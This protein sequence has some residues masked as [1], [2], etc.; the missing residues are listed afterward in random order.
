MS[1][2]WGR[3]LTL[4]IFGESHGAAIGM[5]LAG[6]PPGLRIDWEAVRREMARRAPGRSPLA[7][8]RKEADDFEVLSGEWEGFTTGAPLA[9]IIRNG[10][11]RPSDYP[12]GLLRPGHADLPALRKYRGFADPRGGGH[13]SG[14]LTAPLVLAGAIARQALSARGIALGARIHSIHGA[15][16]I[17]LAPEAILQV[18]QKPFP[19]ADD[20][21]AEAMRQAILTAKEAGDSVGGVIEC[22]AIGVP[23]GLGEPFFDSVESAASALL[24]SIP[25]VKGVSFGDGFAMAAMWGSEAN[26]A[27][28]VQDGEIRPASNHSGGMGGGITNGGA[29]LVSVAI[30]PTPTI[31]KPQQTVDARTGEAACAS[32]G[33]RHDPCIVPRAVPVVE[34]ALAICLLDFLLDYDTPWAGTENG[35]GEERP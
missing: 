26:D 5:A 27:L 7:T 4:S 33:G 8:A 1:N 35:K 12:P 23:A 13:F 31:R 6:L 3:N 10:D 11:T 28:A 25:G 29:L 24:F 15:R 19:V 16:D 18:S 32:F 30:R 9:A 14:R 22:A 20:A 34:A 2:T 21:A 17:Q